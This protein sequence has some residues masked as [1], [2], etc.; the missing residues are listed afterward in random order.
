M[1]GERVASLD[2]GRTTAG[3]HDLPFSPGDVASGVY[4]GRVE[5]A[6]PATGEVRHA[7]IKLLYLK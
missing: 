3:V 2:L 4:I 1:L 6:S 5:A 7:T